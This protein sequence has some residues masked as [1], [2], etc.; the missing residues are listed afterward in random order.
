[1]IDVDVTIAR[2]GFSLEV[3]VTAEDQVTGL[4]G[5]SGS[6]K[7]T[8]LHALSGLVRPDRGRIVVAGETLFD[9]AT[10][11]NLPAHRRRIGVVFQEARL[12]PHL[13]VDA[14]LRYGHVPHGRPAL[15]AVVELLELGTLL[16]RRPRGLSGGERQ[17]VALGRALVIAPRLLLLDEPLSSLDRRLRAQILPFLKRVRDELGVPMV[18]VSHEL[19]EVLQLTDELLLLDRG[20]VTGRG[21]YARLVLDGTEGLRGSEPVNVLELEVHAAA[22][23]ATVLV[24]CGSVDVATSS[25][26]RTAEGSGVAADRGADAHARRF[27]LTGPGSG[28][29]AGRRVSVAIRPEDVALA[30]HPVDQV[31]IRNQIPGRVVRVAP[32][33]PDVLVQVDAGVTLLARIIEPAAREMAL[34]PGASV[35][36]LLKAGAVRYLER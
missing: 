19:E 24:A 22:S 30:R 17:R 25:S 5:R 28:F 6:G 29:V 31:S 1:V 3:A 23:D 35:W 14:N 7:T 12:F 16:T 11:V 15:D 13:T 20:H 33:P 32:H 18:Y 27:E 21:R 2:S 34:E 9:T 10:G 36:C 8:F 4:F 26:T